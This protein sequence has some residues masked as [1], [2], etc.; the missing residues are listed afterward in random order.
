MRLHGK[1]RS[2]TG[3]MTLG[4]L[5]HRKSC[6]RGSADQ[7]PQLARVRLGPAQRLFPGDAHAGNGSTT[8]LYPDVGPIWI[9]L[10]ARNCSHSGARS[11]TA[12][13]AALTQDQ[14][15]QFDRR[16]IQSLRD[17]RVAAMERN[18][19]VPSMARRNGQFALSSSIN[20]YPRM[21]LDAVPIHPD[22]ARLSS[23]E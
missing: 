5:R 13:H 4:G 7:D 1:S 9:Q 22:G 10:R 19:R 16:I 15:R 12:P 18:W 20:P 3:Y 11:L 21:E 6:T 17:G 2:Q 8:L 23:T 14:R